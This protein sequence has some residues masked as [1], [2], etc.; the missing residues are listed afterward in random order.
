MD[1]GIEITGARQVE[2]KFEQFPKEAHDAILQRIKSL[3]SRLAARIRGAVPKG[4]T[5]K[6]ENDILVQ[7]FDDGDRIS[8]RVS[9]SDDFAKAGALEYGAHRSTKVDKHSMSL[10]H[11]WSQ[12]LDRPMQVVVSAYTRTP[13]I[14]EHKF[15]R[16][17]LA[18]MDEEVITEIREAVE[19]VQETDK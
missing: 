5:H 14:T 12:I 7:I 15:L 1:I 4:P 13:N 16:G 2:L 19:A 8:G 10:D 9:I 17:P 18:T 6:L 11:F 3:T